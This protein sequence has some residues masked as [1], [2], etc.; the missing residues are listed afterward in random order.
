M[1][2]TFPR[3]FQPSSLVRPATTN[4]SRTPPITLAAVCSCH[5]FT[6][7]R[8]CIAMSAAW[9]GAMRVLGSFNFGRMKM[10]WRRTDSCSCAG[11]AVSYAFAILASTST[12][13]SLFSSKSFSFFRVRENFLII[14]IRPLRCAT[15]RGIF[16]AFS[17]NPKLRAARDV[18]EPCNAGVD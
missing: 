14:G 9:I 8:L 6:T 12:V 7:D 1:P 4:A 16:L 10:R 3:Q 15:R 5:C 13:K 11:K 18:P 17:V 2:R